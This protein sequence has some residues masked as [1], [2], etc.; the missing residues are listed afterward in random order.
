MQTRR[1]GGNDNPIEPAFRYVLLYLLLAYIG[2]RELQIAGYGYIG[3]RL[4]EALQLLY[5]ENA[6]DV[7]AAVTDVN[8]YGHETSWRYD[9]FG[10]LKLMYDNIDSN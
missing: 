9:G 3:Q 1:A 8:T 6:G 5:I 7:Q 10:S 2:A 4:C